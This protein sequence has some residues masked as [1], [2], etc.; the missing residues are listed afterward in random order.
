MDIV[1]L[2]C[3]IELANVV[4]KRSYP[5]SSL[6]WT[7]RYRC[8]TARAKARTLLSWI[9]ERYELRA[10]GGRILHVF[11]DVFS[12]LVGQQGAVLLTYRQENPPPENPSD[13]APYVSLSA[14]KTSIENCLANNVIATTVFMNNVY[15]ATKGF[16]SCRTFAW[17][18]PIFQ[19]HDGNA[20]AS[21][22]SCKL[23][24]FQ[25]F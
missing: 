13:G 23:F 9:S 3:I 4:M 8:I 2:A 11:D 12:R 16:Q 22:K 17:S 21:L 20:Q 5:P 25:S 18:G 24:S 15:N 7:E 1:Y 14:L 19:V 6:S 10:H